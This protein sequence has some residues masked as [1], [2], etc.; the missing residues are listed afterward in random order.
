MQLGDEK[1]GLL[2]PFYTQS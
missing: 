1:T 2:I